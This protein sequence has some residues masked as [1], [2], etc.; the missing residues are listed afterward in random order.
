MLAANL[1]FAARWHVSQHDSLRRQ[2][3]KEIYDLA[4]MERHFYLPSN[5]HLQG[6]RQLEGQRAKEISR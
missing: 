5:A 4:S 1:L 2:V 6:R 3:T